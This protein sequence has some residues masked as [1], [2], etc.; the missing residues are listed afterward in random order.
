MRP[1]EEKYALQQ[2]SLWRRQFGSAAEILQI[3]AASKQ[4]ADYQHILH[5]AYYHGIRER[6]KEN[7]G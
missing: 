7:P 4:L 3:L 1:K 5:Q 2:K 6:Q